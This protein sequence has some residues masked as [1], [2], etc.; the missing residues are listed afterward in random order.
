[1][2][3]PE[4]TAYFT[5][6]KHG[7]LLLVALAAASVALAVHLFATKSVFSAVAWPVLVLGGIELVIGLTVATRTS[8][9]LADIE[10]GLQARRTV[11]ITTE[12]ERMARVNGTFVLIKK[13]E[14]ALIGISVLFL[15][16][17]PAPATLGSIGLGILLQSAV[18]LA[19]D[20][21]A[22]H[23]ALR[24]VEWLIALPP[25]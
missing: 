13:V 12:I 18:L 9:Q 4:L 14:M 24:Y 19:F 22:H 10:A 7:G 5:A 17:Q 23:R 3:A 20:T 25:T 21:F 8:A 1:M 11:T 6:E 2:P 15:I 16:V